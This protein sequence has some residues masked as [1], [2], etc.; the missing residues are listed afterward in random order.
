MPGS[1]EQGEKRDNETTSLALTKQKI[2]VKSSNEN[3]TD[4][5]TC[6]LEKSKKMNDTVNA[7][8]DP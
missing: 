3:E 5:Y 8:D 7:F 2:K 4:C 6:V 1:E